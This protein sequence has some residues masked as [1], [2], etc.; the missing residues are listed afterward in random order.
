MEGVN[1]AV[2]T[3]RAMDVLEEHLE[4]AR[5][6]LRDY[7]ADIC[8]KAMETALPPLRKINHRV[9]LID[10]LPDVH[11]LLSRVA[12]KRYRSLMDGQ[13][14]Y[15]QIR[16]EPCDVPR[17]LMITPDGTMV[18]NVMQLSDANGVAN[19]WL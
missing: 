16:V 7:S 3:S 12:S 10:P 4:A 18:S 19:L 6:E 11:I 1:I 13:D 9:P 5:Q 17:T 2:L 8:K 15:E 14:A